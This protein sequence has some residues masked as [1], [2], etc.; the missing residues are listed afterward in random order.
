MREGVQRQ[1]G[2]KS[3]VAR[4]GP[5]KPNAAGIELRETK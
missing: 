4:T 1:G 2:E 5:D 3:R